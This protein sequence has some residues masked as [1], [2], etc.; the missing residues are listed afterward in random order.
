MTKRFIEISAILIIIASSIQAGNWI[1]LS[2]EGRQVLSISAA[3]DNPQYI[4][5]GTDSGLYVSFDSGQNW[6]IRQSLSASFPF[7]SY[8]PYSSDSLLML[9]V[10]GTL[11][12]GIFLSINNGNSWLELGNFI[13]PRR[14]GF[15]IINHGFIY[16]CF[17]DGIL[18]SQNYGQSVYT[19]NEGLPGT[20]IL[21]IKGD[22][23]NQYEAYAVGD[24]F[25]AHT[26]NFG[27]SWTEM[28]GAFGIEDYNPKRMEYEPNGPET[29]YVSCYRYVARSY[30][31]G[32]TWHYTFMS[33]TEI[34]PIACDP[35]TPGELYVGSAA[36][37]GVWHSTDTGANFSDLNDNLGNLN[38]HSLI[39]DSDGNLLAGTD[40]GIYKYDFSLYINGDNPLLPDD[41]SLFQ[42]YPNPFN[43]Q[44]I[45][46]F[47]SDELRF[48]RL[49][50]FD[51]RGRLIKTLFEG[52]VAGDHSVTWDGS[53]NNDE[54][55]SAG[56]YIYSLKL[57][58]INVSRKMLIVK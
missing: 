25:L 56:V 17:P 46:K 22:G 37:G 49:D 50:I 2:L 30:N 13:S 38:V 29:L 54:K 5:A 41:I 12:D 26:T 36:G 39:I 18:K 8:L 3:P 58:D 11:L 15:D 44:T 45:I 6:E 31:G 47:S 53:D 43:I 24:D 28:N 19:A 32:L 40:D 20:N 23:T 27:N 57:N 4:N 42:N 51:I 1:F 14:V 48:A 10:E 55:V 9:K 21:D 16:I 33:S 7:L 52:G 35:Q 34:T